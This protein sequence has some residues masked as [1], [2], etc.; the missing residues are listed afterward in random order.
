M[1]RDARKED[2]EEIVELFQIILMDMDLPIMSNVSWETLH[3]ALIEAVKNEE[4]RYSY[5]H[6][7]VKEINGEIAGFCFGYLNRFHSS[8]KK[9]WTEI[10]Q[11]YHLPYF[12][13][14]QEGEA[15]SDEWYLDSL[16]TKSAY[17]GQGV[18][19][20]LMEAAY[21]KTIDSGAAI[22]ALNCEEKNE[23]AR[24][25]YKK[26]GFS[27]SKQI[28]IAGHTYDHMQKRVN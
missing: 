24:S 6:A 27:Q 16:V 25:L 20:E 18:A 21:Q 4:L 1:I 28:E 9:I 11:K 7:I 19:R 2:V 3:P 13:I 17:R 26:E 15:D 22:I 10:L 23:S 8:T 14:Y 5:K 12:E